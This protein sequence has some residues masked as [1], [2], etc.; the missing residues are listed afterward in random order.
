MGIVQQCSHR[1]LHLS[2][3]LESK[4]IPEFGVVESLLIYNNYL[5]Q[6]SGEMSL[7]SWELMTQTNFSS[8]LSEAVAVP[9]IGL[10]ISI[11][12]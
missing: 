7:D 4:Y 8:C 6:P 9:V 2:T 10:P 12:A 3:N 5:V 1:G 11:M